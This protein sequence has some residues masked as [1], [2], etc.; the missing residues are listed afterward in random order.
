[1]I[2]ASDPKRALIAAASV[3]TL[4]RHIKLRHDATRNR[5]TILAPERVLTPDA[6]ALD[7]LRLCDGER[8]VE[9]IAEVLA[10]QYSAPKARIL[11]D[12]TNLLQELADKGVITA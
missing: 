3:P 8:S 5:W 9:A 6:I 4:P 7:I 10:G 1:M 11:T 2:K 12:V